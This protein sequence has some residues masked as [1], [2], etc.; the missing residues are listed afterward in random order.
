MK[1]KARSRTHLFVKDVEDD[2]VLKG[3]PKEHHGVLLPGV[4]GALQQPQAVPEQTHYFYFLVI[5]KK[6]MRD[7]SRL[8]LVRPSVV[9]LWFGSGCGS[10]DPNL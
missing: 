1:Q 8:A 2:L 6:I 10:G 5:E 4:V 7:Y 3:T 9:D